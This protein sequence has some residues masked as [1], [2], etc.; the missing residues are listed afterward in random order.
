[1]IR[2]EIGIPGSVTFPDPDDRQKD[3]NTLLDLSIREN[4]SPADLEF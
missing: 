3:Q 4:H 2:K 1:M